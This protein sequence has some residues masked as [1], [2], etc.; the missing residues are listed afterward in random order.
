M[1]NM[2]YTALVFGVVA[3]CCLIFLY[4]YKTYYTYHYYAYIYTY[5]TLRSLLP[6]HAV[7]YHQLHFYSS[8]R[9]RHF[10][11]QWERAVIPFSRLVYGHPFGPFFLVLFSSLQPFFILLF[12]LLF[13]CSSAV[14]FVLIWQLCDACY[15]GFISRALLY[16]FEFL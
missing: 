5:T 8:S 14:R 3:P 7:F 9:T 6:G 16:L 10:V 11:Q 15:S 1:I 4:I 13:S 12:I 2:Y